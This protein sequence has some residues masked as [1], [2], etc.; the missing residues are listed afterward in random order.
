MDF[1][2]ALSNGISLLEENLAILGRHSGS[3]QKRQMGKE[4]L[5]SESEDSDQESVPDLVETKPEPMAQGTWVNAPTPREYKPM[6][7]HPSTRFTEFHL[8]PFLPTELR[9]KVRFPTWSMFKTGF[10][11]F[12]YQRSAHYCI[13]YN[14]IAN[15]PQIWS[16]NPGP[17]I[18]RAFY[19]VN[20]IYVRPLTYFNSNEHYGTWGF[21]NGFN[22]L[23]NRAVCQE[24]RSESLKLKYKVIRMETDIYGRDP[25]LK[26]RLFNFDTDT[27]FFDTNARKKHTRNE[28]ALPPTPSPVLLVGHPDFAFGANV[29]WAAVTS[30]LWFVSYIYIP[31]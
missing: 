9:F 10:I 3:E 17:Q 12:N 22:T 13:M 25:H 5:G 14:V 29:K 26:R 23:S 6:P 18:L 30:A 2:N 1:P 4:G 15:Y 20:N 31:D 28:R 8:F 21:K 24:S 7:A 27:I 16:F 11:L 19:D